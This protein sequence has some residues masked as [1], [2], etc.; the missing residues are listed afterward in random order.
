[1]RRFLLAYSLRQSVPS[2]RRFLLTPRGPWI[3]LA[4]A[5]CP[6]TME[7]LTGAAPGRCQSLH[8][9]RFLLARSRL[10]CQS[11][12]YGGSYWCSTRSSCLSL[13]TLEV[14]TGASSCPPLLPVP[15]STKVLTG[16]T[17]KC[18]D[19]MDPLHC[20]MILWIL[21]DVAAC[22]FVKKGSYRR[23]TEVR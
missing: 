18:D 7:V 20:T 2:L 13:L 14:L 1:M 9:R 17:L 19:P 10:V 21:S 11:L 5:A 8:T 22:P 3:L 12:H 6:P 16:V 23:N 15:L 4:A